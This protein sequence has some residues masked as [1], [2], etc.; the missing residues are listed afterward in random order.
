MRRVPYPSS[1]GVP[2]M[3][4]PEAS[5]STKKIT[6]DAFQSS[7]IDEPGQFNIADI[8]GCCLAG[9]QNGHRPI[10]SHGDRYGICGDRDLRLHQVAVSSYDSALAVDFEIAGP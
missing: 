10:G 6:A 5:L 1:P 9:L 3:G 4:S 2:V 7:R 8:G